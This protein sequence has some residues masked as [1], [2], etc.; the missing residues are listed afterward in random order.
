MVSSSNL[1]EEKVCEKHEN[2]LNGDEDTLRGN[3]LGPNVSVSERQCSG[4]DETSMDISVEEL[5]IVLDYHNQTSKSV[6]CFGDLEGTGLQI[7]YKQN[8]EKLSFKFCSNY[9]GLKD[10][11]APG[12]LIPEIIGMHGKAEDYDNDKSVLEQTNSCVTRV[13][14]YSLLPDALLRG[15]GAQKVDT[16]RRAVN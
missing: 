5:H 14:I 8:N 11:T 7:K 1:S 9:F 6:V 3:T 16:L 15:N 2:P 4:V 13:L 10:Y 12:K